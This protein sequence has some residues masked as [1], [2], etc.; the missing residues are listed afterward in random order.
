MPFLYI[1]T[2]G[3]GDIMALPPGDS[4]V[5]SLGNLLAHFLG[6]LAADWL[7]GSCPDHRRRVSLEGD[8]S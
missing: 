5:H 8:L 2:D 4:V 7:R 3:V 6:D 1:G